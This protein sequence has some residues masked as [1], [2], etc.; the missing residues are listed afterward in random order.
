LTKVDN[1]FFNLNEISEIIC[2]Q[3]SKLK[4]DFL[5]YKLSGWLQI[6]VVK[7]HLQKLPATATTQNC[8]SGYFCNM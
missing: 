2:V 1:K 4:L 6:T 3:C 8:A 5:N 7:L